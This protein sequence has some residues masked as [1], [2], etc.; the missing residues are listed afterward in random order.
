[1]ANAN[2]SRI[3][4]INLAGDPDALFL[5]IFAGEILATFER[6]NIMLDKHLVRS[7][8][9]G[10]SAQFPV[11]GKIGAN[12]HA[13]GTE[14]NGLT[15]PEAEKVI[16]ID[17]LLISHAFIADIDEAKTHFDV[18]SIYSTE[19]GRKLANVMD[20]NV[21]IE[22][23]KGARAAAA[24]TGY[25]AGDA[26]VEDKFK[27]AA[28][29]G[30][31][32]VKAQATALA[33]GLFSAAQKLD[34]KDVPEED[35]YALFRP[36]EYYA[37]VQNTDLINS[38][39][40]GQGAY[41]DGK[42][43]RIAGIQILKSNNL[44]KTDTTNVADPDYNAFH[45]VNAVK[46]VGLVWQKNA[47]GTVKLMDLSLQSAYDIRRQGTLMVARYAIGHGYLR[48]ECVVELKLNTLTN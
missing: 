48:P 22:L 43:V 10:K 32:D 21:I 1:M 9:E 5:K 4:Q 45:N 3:G 35:R 31:A 16:T 33:S 6:L 15:V 34:E 20:K 11:V 47:V 29:P 27:I 19:M 36:A 44:V 7:I 14:I 42:I 12:Y 38:L 24:I 40:G 23:I 17:D 30:A 41:S 37:L 13:V 8:T 26:V 39:W 46:T 2:P 28:T 18:R 25:P